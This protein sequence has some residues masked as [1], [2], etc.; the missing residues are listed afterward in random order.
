V[1]GVTTETE[2]MTMPLFRDR[3][4]R[5]DAWWQAASATQMLAADP[6]TVTSLALEGE[7]GEPTAE[8]DGVLVATRHPT[9]W[10]LHAVRRDDLSEGRLDAFREAVTVRSYLLLSDGPQA[11]AWRRS[12]VEDEWRSVWYSLARELSEL[13]DAPVE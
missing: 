2:E 1:D 8:V 10:F 6:A 9:G 12:P 7:L 5:P 13:W 11:P 3:G 4:R